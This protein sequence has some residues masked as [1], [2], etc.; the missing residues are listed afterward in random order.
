MRSLDDL[1]SPSDDAWPFVL[2]LIAAAGSRAEIVPC[3]R[4]A[5]EATLSAL[6][7]TTRSPM[8]AIA[9]NAGRIRLD[10]GW[11][12]I[13]GA[14]G[15][16]VGGGLR[17]WNALDGTPALDPPLDGAL[18]VAYDVLGGFFAVNGGA[19]PGELG[20]VHYLAQDTFDRMPLDLTYTS[21]LEFAMAPSLD[22]FYGDLR[23]PGWQD[24]VAALGG[25]E[26]VSVYPPLGFES[27]PIESRSRRPVPAREL[28]GLH[29]T[30]GDQFRDLPDGTTVEFRTVD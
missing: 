11:L 2:G 29:H 14:G 27:T 7:V 5:G 16:G 8:G 4:R 20:I 18:I 17:E 23:W 26:A 10:A 3:A 1:I 9:F 28:W 12:R 25:D 13:L 30:L 21:F 19:W 6:Q 15:D 22:A 24:E